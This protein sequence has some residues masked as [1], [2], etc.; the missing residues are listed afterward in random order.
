MAWFGQR[1]NLQIQ[2]IDIHNF[3]AMRKHL[4]METFFQ[5]SS[6]ASNA[7][8]LNKITNPAKST[9]EVRKK[10]KLETLVSKKNAYS[11]ER[12]TSKTISRLYSIWDLVSFFLGRF[13]IDT[14][15][16]THLCFYWVSFFWNRLGFE[17][18][19]LP[20]SHGFNFKKPNLYLK[21]AL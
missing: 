15:Y 11:A 4:T 18:F 7:K 6:K 19:L 12:F 1:W 10:M 17:I 9:I 5:N 8:K 2:L 20:N 14:L 21:R 16:F 3:V 13:T